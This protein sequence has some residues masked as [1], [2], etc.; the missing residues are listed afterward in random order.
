MEDMNSLPENEKYQEF[1]KKLDE[2]ADQMK[3]SGKAFQEKMQNEIIPKLKKT[4]EDLGRQLN[5]KEKR[6]KTLPL[7]KKLQ[8][9]EDV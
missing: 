8:Q 4:L 5:E 3:E 2:L 9:L 6:E 1:E 7:E